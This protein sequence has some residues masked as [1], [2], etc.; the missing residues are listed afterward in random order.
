LLESDE[1]GRLRG[2]LRQFVSSR[3][4]E[5]IINPMMVTDNLLKKQEMKQQYSGE[6]PS[7]LEK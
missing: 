3:G 4:N 6:K 2:C 5:A 1:S 7:R